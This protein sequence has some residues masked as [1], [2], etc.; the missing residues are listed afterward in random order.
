MQ[1]FANLRPATVLPAMAKASSLKEELVSGL[2]MLIVREL[3]GGVYFGKPR[4]I[5][6][7]ADGTRKAQAAR[8]HETARDAAQVSACGGGTEQLSDAELEAR[9]VHPAE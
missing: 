6:K 3:T 1:L 4:G 5:E 8:A 7:L 2:D 9:T